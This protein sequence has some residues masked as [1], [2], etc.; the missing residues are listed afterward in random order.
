MP[1]F[2]VLLL[3]TAFIAGAIELAAWIIGTFFFEGADVGFRGVTV[4]AT[5]GLITG[6][7]TSYLTGLHQPSLIIQRREVLLRSAVVGG[8]TALAVLLASHLVWYQ[9]LGRTSIMMAGAMTAAAVLSW[10]LVYARFIERGPRVRVAVLGDGEL[11]RSLAS[12]LAEVRHARFDVVGLLGDVPPSDAPSPSPPQLGSYA[13]AADACRAHDV[14]TV[15]VIGSAPL[16]PSKQRALAELRVAGVEIRTAEIALMALLRRTPLE[17]VDDRWLLNLFE[18]LDQS[19][20]RVKRVLDVVVSALGLLGF[21]LLFP[22]LFVLVKLDSSGPFFFSQSRVGLGNRPF[23]LF[24]IR[25]MKVATAGSSEQWAK[26]SDDRTT[27]IGRLLRRT[28]IDELPQFWNVLVGDMSVVGP[29]PEQPS[30]AA[31]L[32]TEISYFSYR[33]LVKP[34]ITGWAQIHFGYA[35][36]VEESRTKLAYDLYYV[37]HHT[38]VLDLDVMLRTFFVML[39]RIGSR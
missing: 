38:L 25:T 6:A 30:I 39:A 10:R 11:E 21:G 9:A 26:Q 13:E 2:L 16:S 7:A 36:T 23:R 17:M 12:S 32:E 37:R 8:A 35:G 3:D 28:R 19:R 18:Q 5:A 31:E 4:S 29:R 1:T 14:D 34:G 27:R 24:K 33:H 15:M 20:D 22:W